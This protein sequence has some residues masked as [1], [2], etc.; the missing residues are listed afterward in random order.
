MFTILLIKKTIIY[1]KISQ[2]FVG[3]VIALTLTAC[4]TDSVFEDLDQPDNGSNTSNTNNGGNGGMTTFSDDGDYQS[5]WDIYNRGRETFYHYQNWTGDW[6]NPAML[7]FRVTPYVGLAYYD[8][9]PNGEYDDPSSGP[10]ENF[11]TVSPGA[12]P[13]MFDPTGNEIGNFMPARPFTLTGAGIPSYWGTVELKIFSMDH[14]HVIGA[15]TVA[16]IYNPNLV[17][18]NISAPPAPYQ[19]STL[20]EEFLL[21]QYGKVFF[22]YWEAV[23][24]TTL[25][26]VSSGYV[27]PR[28]DTGNTTYWSTTGITANLPTGGIGNLYYNIFSYDTGMP[29]HEVVLEG[30][31][32]PHEQFFNYTNTVNGQTKRYKVDVQTYLG[33]TTDLVST[34]KLSI[35]P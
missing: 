16:N 20:Q 4:T 5:I 8:G 22:Y 30:G 17:F 3:G 1:D 33:G 7:H 12:Y 32:Y 31:T 6:G 26:V 25:A 11:N 23:D 10:V 14:C 34:L 13:N 24:P 27:M 21:S 2:Y 9:T 18:F 35:V 29:S 19:P 28:C 15:N